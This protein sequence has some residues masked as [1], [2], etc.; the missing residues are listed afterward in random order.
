M[1]SDWRMKLVKT[2]AMLQDK[3]VKATK[4]RAPSTVNLTSE[5][6]AYALRHSTITD[7]IVLHNL[8]TM[9][10]AQISC[11]SLLMIE[12]HYGHLQNDR[13]ANV[14]AGLSI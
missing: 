4:P 6:T 13:A 7:L 5:A 1:L 9:T 14:L 11:T 10:V 12:K 2:P 8:D 3:A